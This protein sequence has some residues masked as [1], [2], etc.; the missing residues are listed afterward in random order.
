V[1]GYHCWADFYVPGHGWVPVDISEAWKDKTKHDY[2]FG[3]L[4]T[5]R[6]QFTLGRDLTLTPRQEGPPLNFFVY[7]YVEVGGAP[8]AN[9][10]D[11][12]SFGPTAQGAAAR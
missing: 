11:A 2:F 10:D 1:A 6:V 8:Y 12:F 7:P 5:Q 3:T 4:D 9:V